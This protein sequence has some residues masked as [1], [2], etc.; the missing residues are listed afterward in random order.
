[1]KLKYFSIL[2]LMLAALYSVPH[3]LAQDNQASEVNCDEIIA[4]LNELKSEYD[5]AFKEQK[6]AFENW[7]KYFKELHSYSYLDTDKPLI[8]SYKECEG[9]GGSGKDFC[10]GVF[11]NFDEITAKEDPAHEAYDSAEHKANEAR[12]KYNSAV[13]T[14]SDQGC[15]PKK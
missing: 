10:K 11:K 8:D 12:N 13:Q 1:M 15:N 5:A 2:I 3:A 4:N 7:Q 6:K 14:A 9:G